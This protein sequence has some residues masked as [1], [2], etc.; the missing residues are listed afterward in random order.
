[1][2]GRGFL[3]NAQDPA[4]F[5]GYFSFDR[6]FAWPYRVM[7]SI[8]AL[9]PAAWHLV[10]LLL[11]WGGI[12]LLVYTLIE[13]WPRQRL[14]LKWLGAL[15]L[16]YPGFLQQSISGAYNRISQHSSSFHFRSTLRLEARPQ[17]TLCRLLAAAS[18]LTLSFTS[19][20]L[21]TLSVWS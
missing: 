13:L 17:P 1:M 16:V 18:W 5:N 11:R 7:Y 2:T 9:N 20:R 12:L 10:T 4:L 19:L 6:P 3:L 21:S 14:Y 15:M 8:F